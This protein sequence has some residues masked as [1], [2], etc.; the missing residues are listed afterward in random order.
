MKKRD[1]TFPA[2]LE[3]IIQRCESCN[4]AMVDLEGKPYLIPMN[5]GF[6]DNVLYLH[7]A[8]EGKKLEIL[9]KNPEVC[10]SFSTDHVVRYQNKTVGCSYS[11]KYRSVL[12]YGSVD[13]VEDF[14]EKERIMHIFMKHYKAEEGYRFGVPAIKNV[15]VMRIEVEKMEGRVYGY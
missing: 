12:L 10:V 4:V 8:P 14:D 13:F 3:E 5:F 6:E 7:S 1:L 2:H 11:M 9:K 15:C